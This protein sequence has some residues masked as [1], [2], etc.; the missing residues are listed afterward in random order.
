MLRNVETYV[1]P[2]SIEDAVT[3]VQS[4]PNAVYLGGGAWTV[5]QGNPEIETVVDL[6]DLDLDTIDGSLE[7]V[8][9][10]AMVRLQQLIDHADTGSFADGMLAKAAHFT[11]SRTLREQGTLGGTLMVGGHA[12][13]LTTA[14]LALD[15]SLSYADPVMHTA[16][17]TS[18]VA[19]RDRLI[20]T[21]VLLTGLQVKRPSP[22]SFSAFEVVGRSPRDKPVICVAVTIT[23][24]EGLPEALFIA[25][26]G[27]DERPV[28]L[29]KTEHMLRRQLL[30]PERVETALAP[31][32][33]ELHPESDFLGSAQYRLEMTKVL[34][35]R[36]VLTA[37][38]N[39][40]RR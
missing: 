33:Q 34:T 21:R 35:R 12:D 14:L 26:G 17:F 32:L 4:T 5:A 36:A 2:K 1:R 9:I 38:D 7:S 40:R 3:I 16:P 13:P 29:H 22:R 11:Q 6:Q 20:K 18:F 31:A 8:Q 37:W 27:A 24:D 25:V 10:G 15:A 30:S 28:R 19:Y 23:V 39:A